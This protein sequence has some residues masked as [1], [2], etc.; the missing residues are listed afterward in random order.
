MEQNLSKITWLC[1]VILT[2]QRSFQQSTTATYQ[3]L[4]T[5]ESQFYKTEQLKVIF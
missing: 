2:L 3:S 1:L 5:L 4:Q